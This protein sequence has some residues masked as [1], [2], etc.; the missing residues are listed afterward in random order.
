M[1]MLYL[2][3]TFRDLQMLFAAVTHRVEGLSLETLLTLRVEKALI[4][5]VGTRR[6]T[7]CII[8]QQLILFSKTLARNNSSR[9]C[10]LE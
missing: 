5:V 2:L 9:F 4:C 10:R 3:K 8:E 7:V 6:P 1:E